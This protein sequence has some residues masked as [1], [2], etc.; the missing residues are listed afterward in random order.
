VGSKKLCGETQRVRVV[1]KSMIKLLKEKEY[2][3]LVFA[4]DRC[5]GVLFAPAFCG[6]PG[7]SP[8]PVISIENRHGVR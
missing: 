2:R 1:E 7:V 6:K 8:L 3:L 4:E 5:V